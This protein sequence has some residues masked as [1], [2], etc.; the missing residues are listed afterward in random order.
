MS[1]TYYE[2]ALRYANGYVRDSA[3][4]QSLAE[5]E[6]GKQNMLRMCPPDWRDNGVFGPLAIVAQ[7]V[8]LGGW[9]TVERDEVQP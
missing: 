5:A 1:E 9:Q 8:T 6:A 7:K 4:Y 3:P 2:Y